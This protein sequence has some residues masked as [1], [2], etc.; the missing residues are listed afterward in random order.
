M[1]KAEVAELIA[2]K[3]IPYESGKLVQ[4]WART[5]ECRPERLYTPKSEDQVVEVHPL[6]PTIL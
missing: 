2:S 6:T 1:V 4:N 3:Q 5:F